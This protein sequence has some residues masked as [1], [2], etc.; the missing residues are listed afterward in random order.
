MISSGTSHI[1][2]GFKDSVNWKCGIWTNINKRG[3]REKHNLWVSFKYSEFDLENNKN[4]SD[5]CICC[6]P[7]TKT[8]YIGGVPEKYNSLTSVHLWCWCPLYDVVFDFVS[9]ITSLQPSTARWC[10]FCK[11][12]ICHS[13]NFR[14]VTWKSM[15]PEC[16]NN[17]H[18]YEYIGIKDILGIAPWR[19]KCIP[20]VIVF[21]AIL[22]KN[23][24]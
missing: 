12:I 18:N 16:Q 5:S 7:Y 9:E 20:L 22:L 21:A 14:C 13:W 24:R 3:A 17:Q 2:Q 19:I 4:H 6:D 23:A 10:A 1:S 8:I 11:I 15:P